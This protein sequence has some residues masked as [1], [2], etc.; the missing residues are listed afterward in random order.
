MSKNNNRPVQ[1]TIAFLKNMEARETFQTPHEQ[2]IS[3]TVIS[4]TSG[5]IGFKTE[6][7]KKYEI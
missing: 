7:L 5:L 3:I 4:Q 2:A 6:G 1:E